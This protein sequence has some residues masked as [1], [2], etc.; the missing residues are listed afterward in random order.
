MRHADTMLERAPDTQRAPINTAHNSAQGYERV[1]N[2]VTVFLCD[3]TTK[4]LKHEKVCATK[5]DFA[6]LSDEQLMDILLNSMAFS[7]SAKNN[8]ID[9]Y[10]SLEDHIRFAPSNCITGRTGS[11]YFRSAQ[12][13]SYDEDGAGCVRQ[14]SIDTIA[15]DLLTLTRVIGQ[16]ELMC[17]RFSSYNPQTLPDVSDRIDLR[18]ILSRRFSASALELITGIQEAQMASQDAQMI[19]E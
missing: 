4:N 6:L 9:A 10:Q 18:K 7:I 5:A 12:V 2:G 14:P 3:G 15:D 11:V 1:I 19:S 17:L 16:K 8:E 13:D